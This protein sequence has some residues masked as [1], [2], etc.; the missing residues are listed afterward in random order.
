VS[1][2]ARQDRLAD[3]PAG[4]ERTPAVGPDGS[5]SATGVSGPGRLRA[6]SLI[7]LQRRAGNR[8]VVQLL[9]AG[10]PSVPSAARIAVPSRERG[11]GG[12]PHAPWPATA[13][14]DEPESAGGA[15][16]DPESLV[17]AFE[18]VTQDHVPSRAARK[19]KRAE[20]DAP[21]E[22]EEPV[23]VGDGA[24]PIADA[25]PGTG[26][27]DARRVGTVPFGETPVRN[28]SGDEETGP[29]EPHAFAAGGR[30]GTRAWGGGAGAGP[31]GNQPVGSLEKVDPVYES[32]WGGPLT[33]ASAW[34]AEGT[35][36]V[37]VK[38]DYV[39]SSPG[40]QGNGWYITDKAAAA[41]EAHERRHVAK[42]RDSYV[43]RIQPVLDRILNSYNYG[44]EIAYRSVVATALVRRYVNWPASIK[45]FVD[46]DTA[47]NAKYARV[48]L[49][50][51]ASSGY[52]RQIGPGKVNGKD[53]KNRLKLPTEPSPPEE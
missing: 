30:T 21:P 36:T 1:D 10:A 22:I 26:F 9:R 7:G 49:E 19:E 53:F 46:D 18:K 3:E 51:Q 6:H 15:P 11:A 35:G 29:P 27:Q 39:S 34:V 33:N 47:W 23:E 17:G 20:R 16:P 45:A 14:R 50:D 48:D 52:P 8:A 40:D 2:H 25:S 31:K 28:I 44:K 5:P 43:D 37:A 41:L 38:R 4:R 12:R 24:P 13:D 32:A 42:S